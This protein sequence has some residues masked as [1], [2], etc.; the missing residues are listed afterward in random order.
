MPE[1]SL[2]LILLLKRAFS[3]RLD[4]SMISS[5]SFSTLSGDSPSMWK[6]IAP[7]KSVSTIKFSKSM[8]VLADYLAR[9][10]FFAIKT[11]RIVYHT[12]HITIRASSLKAS[13]P[14][15]TPDFEHID[16]ANTTLQH[17]TTRASKM[18]HQRVFPLAGSFT[19]FLQPTSFIRQIKS[20]PIS[21]FRMSSSIMKFG[22]SATWK[23]SITVTM[24]R[25]KLKIKSAM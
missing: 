2:T 3:S 4:I 8:S 12:H 24:T 14:L 13:K 10:C 18:F 21:T 5:G 20:I 11:M 9:R 19:Y 7:P 15:I 23:P 1:P 16:K 17:V 6:K 22:E 25:P